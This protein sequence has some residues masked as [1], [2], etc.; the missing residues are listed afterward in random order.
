MLK[1]IDEAQQELMKVENEY[2]FE[3]KG[4]REILEKLERD[5]EDWPSRTAREYAAFEVARRAFPTSVGPGGE[6]TLP[7]VSYP[8]RVNWQATWGTMDPG[9]PDDQIRRT[10]PSTIKP[11]INHQ[12]RE[13]WTMI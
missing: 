2:G 9:A 12:G 8:I 3:F 10:D 4:V 1:A 5:L 7:V 13:I 6:E 11:F